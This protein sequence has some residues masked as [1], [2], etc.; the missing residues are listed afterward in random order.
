MSTTSE[1]KRKQGQRETGN[2]N[3]LSHN[4]TWFACRAPHGSQREQNAQ[5]QKTPNDGASDAQDKADVHFTRASPTIAAA[6]FIRQKSA[7]L[8]WPHLRRR[9][10]RR[11][12][13]A[14]VVFGDVEH[15]RIRV[16]SR[17]ARGECTGDAERCPG[18]SDA[19]PSDGAAQKRATRYGARQ[20]GQRA[21]LSHADH[22][23]LLITW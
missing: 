10:C 11:L 19:C 5:T 7:R 16:D 4:K 6:C 13:A 21:P 3:C 8:L 14:S 22:D 18:R 2:A 15:H 9:D 20:Q 1:P 23:Q 17:H 12:G